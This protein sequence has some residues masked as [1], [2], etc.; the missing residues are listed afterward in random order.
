MTPAVAITLLALQAAPADP[1]ATPTT[2]ATPAP[3]VD[4]NE[5]VLFI[6]EKEEPADPNAPRWHMALGAGT[7]FPMGIAARA[8]V[9]APWRGR[10]STSIGILPGA[11]VDG[12]N[13]IVTGLGGYSDQT[14][15]LIKS[16]LSTSLIWRTHLGYRLFPKLGLYVEAGYGLVT[17]GG[18]VTGA[19]IIQGVTGY[20]A[21]ESARTQSRTFEVKSTLHMLDVEVG[22]DLKIFE[23]LLLRAALGGAFTLGANT[24]LDAQ[25][26]PRSAD[27]GGLFARA[28]SAYLDDIYTSYVFTPVFGV[29]ASYILF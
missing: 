18:S 19:E 10:V 24:S 22:Y 7:D 11:Y 23:R 12:I 28:A 3:V 25:F 2:S 26:T 29:S 21:P 13:G 27:G 1:P 14:A 9:E 4:P 15:D 6:P 17:L 5:P 16:A 8:H 20:T